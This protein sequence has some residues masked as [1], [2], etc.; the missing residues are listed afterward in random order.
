[1][2]T[3]LIHVVEILGAFFIVHKLW[4]KGVTYGEKE[5]W[6]REYR[7]RRYSQSQS[8]RSSRRSSRR[9]EIEDNSL[10]D[11]SRGEYYQGRN[12]GRPRREKTSDHESSVIP[13]REGDIEYG[14]H[15]VYSRHAS[16]SHYYDDDREYERPVRY[17]RRASERY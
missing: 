3:H 15:P 10:R 5:E 16:F 1:M 13:M 9:S 4:P 12:S 17:T 8:Q 6:E 14:A 2:G 11:S 7:R